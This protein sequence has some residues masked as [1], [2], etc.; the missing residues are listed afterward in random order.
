MK[1][2]IQ[3]NFWLFF[4]G[5]FA[6]FGTLVG[7][8]FF[9]QTYKQLKLRMDGVQ[10]EGVVVDTRLGSDGGSSP[11][12]AF[13]TRTGERVMYQ[14]SVYTKPPEYAVGDPVLLWYDP[15][16]PQRALLPGADS[17]LVVLITG[18]FFLIFGG[19]GYGGL[20]R[21]Y[22]KKRRIAWL[23]QNGTEVA[24]TFS[25][26]RFIGNLKV[27][28]R[29]PYVILGQW[30]DPAT[31]T[32]YHFESEYLW[33]DPGPHLDHKALRVLIDPNDPSNYTMDVDFLPKPD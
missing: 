25:E 19:I 28:G 21:F 17:W 16:D 1:Q 26:V 15:H 11:T 33:Y 4:F 5:F 10:A 2:W 12:I 29:S 6:T 24:A 7:I 23:K 27:N 13:T 20:L 30:K 22:L 18:I 9:T 3:N 14:S 31:N 8:P 32:E